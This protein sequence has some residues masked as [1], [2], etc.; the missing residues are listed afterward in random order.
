MYQHREHFCA[1]DIFCAVLY[2]N[3][4][5][6]YFPASFSNFNPYEIY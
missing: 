5:F 6:S 3:T 4:T 2:V 1:L